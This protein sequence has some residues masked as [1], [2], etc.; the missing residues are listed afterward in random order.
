[1]P[2][3]IS[4]QLMTHKKLSLTSLAKKYSSARFLFNLHASQSQP[5]RR[6]KVLRV[7]LKVASVAQVVVAVA[8]VAVAVALDVE[9]AQL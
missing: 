1:M 8:A 5:E 4:S 6:L 3:S 7:T 2:L 9:V